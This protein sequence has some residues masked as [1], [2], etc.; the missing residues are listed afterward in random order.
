MM[1]LRIPAASLRFG[2]LH[3]LYAVLCCIACTSALAQKNWEPARNIEVI[4][5][6]TPG[7]AADQ[8][9]RLIQQLLQQTARQTATVVNKPG[10]SYSASFL[11]LNQHP[12]D[13][14]YIAISPINLVTNRTLGIGTISEK[15][16]TP[17][18]Q[19]ISDYHA[20]SVPAASPIASASDLLARLRKDPAAISIAIS[21]SIGSAN[22]FA[23]MTIFKAAGVDI[24]RLK[25]VAFASGGE[26]LTAVLGGHVDV[27]IS[28]VPTVSPVL[29][30]GKMRA[31]AVTSPKRLS[32]KVASVPTWKEAGVNSIFSNWRGV[33]GPRG[34]SATQIEYWDGALKR[35]TETDV[36]KKALEQAQQEPEYMNSP[37]SRRFLEAQARELAVLLNELGLAKPAPQ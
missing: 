25:I 37:E 7:G 30:A 10:A 6:T 35:M 22:H 23:A 5:G 26:S 31:L 3:A 12:G 20:F 17:I 8:S 19:L 13:A 2:A 24:K 28:A 4:V 15:D 9:A 1:P 32:G 14:H 16:I 33:V 21:P 34:L 11:Y 29:E 18:A 36:W 27:L